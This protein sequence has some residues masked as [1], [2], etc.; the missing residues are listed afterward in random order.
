MSCFLTQNRELTCRSGSAGGI[1]TV[2]FLGTSGATLTSYTA[3]TDNQITGVTG[4]GEMLKYE[5]PR[6]TASFVET[7]TVNDTT[8]SL[9]FAQTLTLNLP[10]MDAE[11]RNIF[12][13]LAEQQSIYAVFLDSNSRYWFAFIDNGGAVSAGD[14]QT[15][16]NFG[17]PNGLVGLTITGAE[18]N[19][20]RELLSP[21]S[22]F[23][24]ITWNA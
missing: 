24:G 15:G 9:S 20:V 6:N 11:L 23:T 19:S 13:E 16:L 17:D 2:W 12:E 1:K 21:D 8:S 4:V 3:N 5:V 22:A 14:L 7:V 18:G 10:K